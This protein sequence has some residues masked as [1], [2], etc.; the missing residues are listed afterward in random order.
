MA[1]K[2][3]GY[4]EAERRLVERELDRARFLRLIGAGATLP[5]VSMSLAARP[6]EAQAT[7]TP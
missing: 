4:G 6:S 7:A 1:G 3:N 5:F 2:T